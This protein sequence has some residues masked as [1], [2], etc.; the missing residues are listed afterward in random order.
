MLVFAACNQEPEPEPAA[1]LAVNFDGTSGMLTKLLF[2]DKIMMN[3][4]FY[5]LGHTNLP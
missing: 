4:V 3:T 5:S 2:R 1:A